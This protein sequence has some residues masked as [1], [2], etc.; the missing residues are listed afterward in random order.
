MS[1]ILA[2]SLLIMLLFHFCGDQNASNHTSTE[3]RN[4]NSLVAFIDKGWNEKDLASI[5]NYFSNAFIRNVN[6]VKV[7]SD[8]EELAAHMQVYFTGFPDLTIE[9]DNIVSEGNQIY[10]SW[11]LNGTNTGQFGDLSATGKRIK[12]S[13]MSL[14]D[15]NEEGKIIQDK[16][17]YNELSLLQ[18]MG[19]T[20]NPPNLQ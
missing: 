14:I 18:Q 19:H 13:G 4:K 9:M 6:N 3:V 8:R 16:V 1:R 7:A 20:L 2:K 10:L 15:F 17:F 11:T 12:I 5:N